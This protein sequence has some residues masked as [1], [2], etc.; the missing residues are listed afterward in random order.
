MTASFCRFQSGQAASLRNNPRQKFPQY[1]GKPDETIKGRPQFR[2]LRI[3]VGQVWCKECARDVTRFVD[4]SFARVKEEQVICEGE[5]HAGIGGC[6]LRPHMMKKSG[7]AT[8][9]AQPL[10]H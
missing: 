10:I 6:Q 3:P 9:V 4:D 7:E 1:S 8:V 2:L 5:F